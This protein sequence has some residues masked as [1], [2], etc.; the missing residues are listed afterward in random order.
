MKII[1]ILTALI[2]VGC[3]VFPSTTKISATSKLEKIDNPTLKVEQ[4]FKWE[5]TE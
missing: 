5:K 2:M 3:V 1:L 4:N